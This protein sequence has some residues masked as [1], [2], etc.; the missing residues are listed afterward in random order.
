MSAEPEAWETPE[1]GSPEEAEV[2]ARRRK[3][4]RGSAFGLDRATTVTDT[5]AV[6]PVVSD[7]P[8]GAERDRLLALIKRAADLND[9]KFPPLRFVVDGI[10]PEGLG[11][12]IG[13]PK[14]GKS[15][16]AL[17]IAL[18]IASGGLA[19]GGIEVERGEVLYLAMEDGE[20]RLQDRCGRLLEG[21]P[22]PDGLDYVTTPPTPGDVVGIVAV[23]LDE[24]PRGV[25][26][27]DTLG[28]VMPPALPGESAYERDYRVVGAFKRL[29]DKHPGSAVIIVHH[30]RKAS[31][32]DFVDAV[33]GT[34]GLAGAADFIVVL[35]R[36][37]NE[38]AALL[39]VTGR[40]VPEHE[41]AV[42]VNKGRW[43]L[44]DGDLAD[45][46]EAAREVRATAGVGARSREVI[47]HVLAADD[48]V[49]PTDVAAAVGVDAKTAGTYLA[50][51]VERGVI[52]RTGRG[53]YSATPGDRVGSVES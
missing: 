31:S 51:A 7:G 38:T 5:E 36:K 41:Y 52:V 10:M 49:T 44:R 47:A 21:E 45:A 16:A 20:R 18:A 6:R 22:I 46:A 14:A 40:D 50:R 33:S 25:V 39:K 35:D 4:R 29:A 17:G 13:P 24:H 8:T 30:D 32:E 27:I 26:I 34:H 3:E 37:R 9:A 42:D 19:L 23:W 12:L 11:L 1:P 43:T 15:W 28:K 53:H 2:A 48:A